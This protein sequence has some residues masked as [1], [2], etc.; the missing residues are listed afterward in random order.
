MT[1]GRKVIYILAKAHTKHHS[2]MACKGYHS[3]F[4]LRTIENNIA[5]GLESGGGE[6]MTSEDEVLYFKR[7]YCHLFIQN[8]HVPHFAS[9]K[10]H[11]RRQTID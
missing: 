10:R 1:L 2:K 4:P 8:M 7:Y 3:W 5:R 11:P 6:F 9:K